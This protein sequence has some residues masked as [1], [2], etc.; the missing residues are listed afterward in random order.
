MPG[1]S[2]TS[3]VPCVG[4]CLDLFPLD[5]HQTQSRRPQPHAGVTCSRRAS[6]TESAPST[7]RRRRILSSRL[8][9]VRDPR[10]DVLQAHSAQHTCNRTS[11]HRFTN[12]ATLVAPNRLTHCCIHRTQNRLTRPFHKSIARTRCTNRL[13][14]LV[15]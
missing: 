5:T 9:V 12:V 1:L 3:H 11:H 2:S 6:N 8:L 13:H 15:A 4:T 7:S 14:G 10:I